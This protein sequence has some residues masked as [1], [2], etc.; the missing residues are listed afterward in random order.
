MTSLYGVVPGKPSKFFDRNAA[1][2]TGLR[3]HLETEAFAFYQPLKMEGDPLWIDVTELMQK[4][5]S[6]VG[7]FIT[8]LSRQATAV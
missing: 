2:L 7:E 8:R 1:A 4:G 3:F 6:G 5:N